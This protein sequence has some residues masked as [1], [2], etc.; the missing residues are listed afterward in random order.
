[1]KINWG[2]KQK[3]EPKEVINDEVLGTVKVFNDGLVFDNSV[4]LITKA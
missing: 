1:M 4:F 3:P 2:G